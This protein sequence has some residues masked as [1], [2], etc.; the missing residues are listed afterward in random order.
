MV[1]L[2]ASVERFSVSRMRDFVYTFSRVWQICTTKPQVSKNLLKLI[3]T[4][5]HDQ[6]S[7]ANC[8]AC[9]SWIDSLSR[10]RESLWSCPSSLKLKV[11]IFG[12]HRSCSNFKKVIFRAAWF[13]WLEIWPISYA[14]RK[15]FGRLAPELVTKWTHHINKSLLKSRKLPYSWPLSI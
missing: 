1:I 9:W 12:S 14:C 5:K 3:T 2:S 11:C 15:H 7:T 4:R 13:K 10:H 8:S 6:Y